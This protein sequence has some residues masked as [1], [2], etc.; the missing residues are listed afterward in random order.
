MA[1]VNLERNLTPEHMGW[2]LCGATN[3]LRALVLGDVALRGGE[4]SYLDVHSDLLDLDYNRQYPFKPKNNVL[5]TAINTPDLVAEV[6]DTKS[7]T[8]SPELGYH[9]VALGGVLFKYLPESPLAS[10]RNIV[11]L[12]KR[13]GKEIEIPGTSL[14]RAVIEQLARN[15]S[16]SGIRRAEVINSTAEINGCDEG[17]VRKHVENLIKIGYILLDEKDGTLRVS[18]DLIDIFKQYT[19]LVS[20]FEGDQQLRDD[21]YEYLLRLLSGDSKDSFKVPYFA[22][23]SVT[24][25]GRTKAPVLEKFVKSLPSIFNGDELLLT[26]EVA[27]RTGIDTHVV[28][29]LL[30][31]ME[32]TRPD[33]PVRRT[34]TPDVGKVRVRER[35][36][37]LTKDCPAV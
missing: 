31:R 10:F 25:S 7:I 8:I 9:A 22:R 34:N 33:A 5:T 4:A 17:L 3:E 36:W 35:E 21:G 18:P 24:G 15:S 27:F 14:R 28:F 2:V 37:G 16:V 23:R 19:E 6:D 13:T 30:Q 1:V 12:Y 26:T 29:D 20:S 32:R 11:G